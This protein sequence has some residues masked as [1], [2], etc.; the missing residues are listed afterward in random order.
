MVS[1]GLRPPSR[2]MA[3]NGHI[4]SASLWDSG[5][6]LWAVHE[7]NWTLGSAVGT[8]WFYEH[9]EMKP[10]RSGTVNSTGS[11][12]NAESEPKSGIKGGSKNGPNF[13]PNMLGPWT[14]L[15]I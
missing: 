2:S 13:G 4:W 7:I 1:P 15:W 11:I 6:A 10:H 14:E 8:I 12:K 5:G 3:T 9:T